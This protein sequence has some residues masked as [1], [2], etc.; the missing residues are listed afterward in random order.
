MR[1]CPS[2]K[3]KVKPTATSLAVM[4]GVWLLSALLFSAC[5]KGNEGTCMSGVETPC[6]P[7][8][9]PH[10]RLADYGLFIGEISNL[11]PVDGLI[12]YDLNTPLFTDYAEKS[13]FIYVPSD[14]SIV[15]NADNELVFPVGSTLVK[16]FFYYRNEQNE[17]AGRILVETRLMILKQYGWTANTYVWNEEQTEAILLQVGGSR[18]VSWLDREGLQRTVSYQIPS[19]NDCKTCHSNN[20]AMVL[21]GP[22]VRNL[23][24][25]FYYPD[26]M[27]T[28][29]Q[30]LHWNHSGILQGLPNPDSLSRLPV[31]NLSST[32]TLNE[33]ARAYLDV[34]CGMCHN[35][36]GSA[37]NS[38]L[39][40]NLETPMGTNLGIYKRPLAPG[41]GSGDLD[42]DIVPGKPDSSIMVYRMESVEPQIRMPELGRTLVHDEAVQLIREWIEQMEL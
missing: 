4:V 33:R 23:N 1:A 8:E 7:E 15:Y 32:G 34:N 12:P 18:Q 13:R 38:R 29:N 24:Q 11:E 40:L 20:N 27:E 42:Y 39:F 31:W 2:K 35:P 37:N 16:N 6:I 30:L 25:E 36:G 26:E 10:Y 19:I 3:L 14:S 5:M 17:S 28:E 41:L 21:L 22:K 9:G